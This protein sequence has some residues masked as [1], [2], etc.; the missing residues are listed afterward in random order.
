MS[1]FRAY[2]HNLEHYENFIPDVI[3]TDYAD[4]FAPEDKRLSPRHQLRQIWEEHKALAQ[5]RHCLVITA[6][7]SSAARTEKDTKQGDWS[8]AISKLE[9]VD[10]GFILNQTPDEKREGLMRVVVAKQRHDDFDILG[11]VKVLQCYKIGKPY[12]DSYYG[13]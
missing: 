10:V 3:V 5:E 4:K 12:L 6:S 13:R 1:K 2:L 11:E 9:L 8:E 7:Q